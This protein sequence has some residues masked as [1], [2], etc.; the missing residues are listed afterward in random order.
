MPSYSISSTA[1]IAGTQPPVKKTKHGWK[2]HLAVCSRTKH[3]KRS[4]QRNL[5]LLHIGYL[6]SCLKPRSGLLESEP[7]FS[8]RSAKEIGLKYVSPSSL[9]RQEDGSFRDEDLANFIQN[10]YG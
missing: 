6:V 9:Q 2:K 1:C 8:V 3:R 10:A 5:R 4:R 7:S